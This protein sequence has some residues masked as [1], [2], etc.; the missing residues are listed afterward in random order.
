MK[1]S[2][3]IKLT[4]WVIVAFTVTSF[5]MEAVSAPDTILNTVGCVILVFFVFISIKTKAFINI[6]FKKEK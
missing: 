6:N 1:T 5:C 2:S 4:I 3:F